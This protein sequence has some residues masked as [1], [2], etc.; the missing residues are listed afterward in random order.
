MFQP[1]QRHLQSNLFSDINNLTDKARSDLECSWAG[2]FYRE[3][4]CRLDER[5]FAVLY[6]DKASRPNT[7]INVLVGLEALKSGFG[8]TDAEMYDHFR[9]DV[10]VRYALGLRNLGEGEFDLRTVY[11]FRLRLSQHRAE[12]GQ[13]LIDQ[14]FAQ[15]TDEQ[16]EAFQLQT[17]CLRMDSTQVASNI[18]RM[19]RLQLLVEMLQRVHRMLSATDQARY[20]EAFAPYLKGSSGQYIYHIRGEETRSH[21][22]QIGELMQRLLAELQPTYAEHATYQMLQRVFAEQFD[23]VEAEVQ[24]KRGQDIRPDRLRSPD[25]PDATYRRKGQR[26]YEGY[27]SNVAET[28][29]ASNPFQ[30]IVKVQTA[31]N[32]VEDSTLLVE[33]LPELKAR[34]DVETLYNDAG[35][36]SEQADEALAKEQVTQVPTDLRGKAPNPDKY[37][38]ADFELHTDAGGQPKQITCPHGQT[39]AVQD[40]PKSKNHV[41]YFAASICD[42]CPSQAKCPTRL[43]KR[44]GRR[45][46]CFGRKQMNVAQRR[47]RCAAYHREGKNPRA[48]VEATV[49]ALKRPWANDQLPVRGLFRMSML[50]LCSA[51]MV[52][53]RRIVRYEAAKRAPEPPA[54]LTVVVQDTE[55]AHE[56]SFVSRLRS[57]LCRFLA[58][59]GAPEPLFALNC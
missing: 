41:A 56:S 43:R 28:C 8:W 45:S 13:D 46:L 32:N 42:H 37:N 55:K 12:T 18:R 16:I 59:V 5:P 2:V 54:T 52:N 22:Q 47:R 24:A 26:E 34:T 57:A 53:I 31:P 27:V 35:F 25:D 17:R 39:V 9:Y 44:D 40:S 4:F 7:P 33:A 15:V 36:C 48:A 50:L 11:N 14:A 30:L 19:T 51:V 6:S 49:G 10:Q 1:N 21:M 20:E 23:L 38:L 3:F 29:D 58:P